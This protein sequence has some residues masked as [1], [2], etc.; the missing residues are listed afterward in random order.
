MEDGAQVWY[1]K[2]RPA[3]LGLATPV[4]TLLDTPARPGP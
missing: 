4:A 3:P 1:N 2:Q